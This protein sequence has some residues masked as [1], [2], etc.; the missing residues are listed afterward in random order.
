V[1][2]QLSVSSDARDIINS[3]YKLSGAANDYSL[4]EPDIG[5]VL[6]GFSDQ[7]IAAACY[8]I[9]KVHSNYAN[10]KMLVELVL[11]GLAMMV[12]L[13]FVVAHKAPFWCY[14]I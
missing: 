14:G 3:V 10:F 12:T 6:S 7:S 1:R 13:K 8:G 2:H 9:V 5:G 4:T 11:R